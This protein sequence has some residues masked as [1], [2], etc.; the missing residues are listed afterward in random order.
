MGE[1]IS[2]LF[3][4]MPIG[5]ILVLTLPIGFV[6]IWLSVLYL[7]G[8]SGQLRLAWKRVVWWLL[9]SPILFGLIGF[10][11]LAAIGGHTP[12]G[13]DFFSIVVMLL[14]VLVYIGIVPVLIFGYWIKKKSDAA[15]QMASSIASSDPQT[16]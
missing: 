10:I 9:L 11:V 4:V 1:G 14:W 6:I 2:F 15:N 5:K 16:D 12:D 3:S 13:F 7:R 8:E